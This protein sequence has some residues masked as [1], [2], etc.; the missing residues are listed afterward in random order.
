MMNKRLLSSFLSACL[1]ATPLS[2]LAEVHSLA[3]LNAFVA[4]DPLN[5]DNGM[6]TSPAAPLK[7]GPVNIAFDVD[8]NAIEAVDEQD[9]FYANGYYYLIGQ[10]YA[11]GE[12]SN[13]LICCFIQSLKKSRGL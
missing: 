13:L 11:E 1:L 9:L 5:G 8:G 10:S 4:N 7:Y 3:N 12:I 6:E 2:A